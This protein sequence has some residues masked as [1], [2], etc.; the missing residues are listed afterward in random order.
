MTK[1]WREKMTQT[2][3]KMVKIWRKKSDKRKKN[4]EKNR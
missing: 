1:I 3:K 4:Y 2:E